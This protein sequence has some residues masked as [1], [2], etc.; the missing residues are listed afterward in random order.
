MTIQVLEKI[1]ALMTLTSGLNSKWCRVFFPGFSRQ[2]NFIALGPTIPYQG[3]PVPSVE[4]VCCLNKTNC[5]VEIEYSAG[6]VYVDRQ[7]LRVRED[8]GDPSQ[9]IATFY[10]EQKQYYVIGHQ[11][12]SFCPFKGKILNTTYFVDPDASYQG[13]TVCPFD[14][15]TRD[16]Y[17]EWSGIPIINVTMETLTWWLNLSTTPA[18]P[19]VECLDF[20]PYVSSYLLFVFYFLRRSV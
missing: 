18:T 8:L 3:A 10:G 15:I 13:Q 4:S 16:T 19:V 5:G 20:A 6:R 17:Y 9:F 2:E 14:G 1:T 11:C 12:S 7:N